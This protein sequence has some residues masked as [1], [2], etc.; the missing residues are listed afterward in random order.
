MCRY[1]VSKPSGVLMRALES[2]LTQESK[3]WLVSEMAENRSKPN[4]CKEYSQKE[5]VGAL[6]TNSPMKTH[7]GSLELMETIKKNPCVLESIEKALV[8]TGGTSAAARS[9]VVET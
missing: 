3:D 7:W 9:S 4:E 1:D 2:E 8:A 6:K 5:L